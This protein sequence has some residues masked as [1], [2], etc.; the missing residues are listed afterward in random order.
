MKWFSANQI[1]INP[2]K[3]TLVCCRRPLQTVNIDL[4]FFFTRPCVSAAP[5]PLFHMPTLLTS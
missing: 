4:P 3:T 1:K 2:A 5:V